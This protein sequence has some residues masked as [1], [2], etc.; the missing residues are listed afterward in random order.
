M[1][2]QQDMRNMTALALAVHEDRITVALRGW[3]VQRRWCKHDRGRVGMLQIHT[4]MT[5]HLDSG[6]QTY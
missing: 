4:V 1:N 6:N 5:L 2:H 3:P